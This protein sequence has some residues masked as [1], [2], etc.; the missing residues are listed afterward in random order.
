MFLFFGDS[1]SRQ[2]QADNPGIWGH[3][4]FTGATIKGLGSEKSVTNHG[5]IIRSFA[6]GRFSK[7]ILL[8]F[9]SVDLDVTFYRNIALGR[10]MSEDEFF[11]QRSR[12]Y[13]AYVDDLLAEADPHIRRFCILAPQVSPLADFAFLR[14]TARMAKLDEPD[15]RTVLDKIDCSHAERCRRQIRFNNVLSACFAGHERAKLYRV[16]KAMVDAN[17]LI[18][19]KFR[20]PNPFDHHARAS[21]TLP[22]WQK[23]LSGLIPR[24]KQHHEQRQRQLA[25]K[26]AAA[27]GSRGAGRDDVAEFAAA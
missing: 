22:L 5:A 6:T 17:G 20:R 7:T 3:I 16:D 23:R 11:E 21:E 12:L 1:H 15:F 14:A 10:A 19:R 18:R 2:F 26:K 9:G 27:L 13:R 4:S 8:M 24:Y 25:E